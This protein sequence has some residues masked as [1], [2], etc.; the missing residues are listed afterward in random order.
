MRL[1]LPFALF[2]L[3]LGGFLL[4]GAGVLA[5]LRSWSPASWSAAC[6]PASWSP[7]R[8]PAVAALVS[9]LLAVDEDELFFRRARR[10]PRADG[11]AADRP[12]GC[13]SCRSTGWATTPRA[14][15]C[16]TASM[17]T[18]AA[19]LRAGSHVLTSWHTD[20]SSQTGAGVCGILHGSNHDILG[21]RWYEKDRDHI[22][23]RLHPVDAAEIER[24]H[25]DGR[26]LLAGDGAGRGNLFTGDAATSA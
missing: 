3:G 13:C 7:S 16:A 11:R 23:P 8:W 26:G 25:S 24:R 9:S 21:F 2:T 18:L 15:R 14:G 12:P 17:P 22:V 20:W 6:G 10:R 1:A 4:L 5:R 19:W